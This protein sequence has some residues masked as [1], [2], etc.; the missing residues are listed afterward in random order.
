MVQNILFCVVLTMGALA[1]IAGSS[2]LLAGPLLL[3]S[4]GLPF[5][6][7]K[8]LGRIFI[9]AGLGLIATAFVFFKSN[10]NRTNSSNSHNLKNP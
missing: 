6:S 1:I 10:K 5:L 4:V 9:G 8:G 2:S 3:S 7:D